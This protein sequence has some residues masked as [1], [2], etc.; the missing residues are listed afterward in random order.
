LK[1]RLSEIDFFVDRLNWLYCSK[2]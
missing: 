1:N 2:N